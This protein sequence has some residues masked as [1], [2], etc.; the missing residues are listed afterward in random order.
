VDILDLA[1][2]RVALSIPD[3]HTRPVHT[4]R[5][6]AGS[7]YVDTPSE[8]H[9]LFLTS[10]TDSCVKLWD[11]RTNKYDTLPSQLSSLSYIAGCTEVYYDL[12]VISIVNSQLVVISLPVVDG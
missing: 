10:A 6:N 3:C 12:K 4:I 7:R 11:M 5:I 9:E 2:G 1:T 8:S